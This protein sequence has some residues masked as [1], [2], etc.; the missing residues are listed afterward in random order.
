MRIMSK[1]KFRDDCQPSIQNGMPGVQPFGNK[2]RR[3]HFFKGADIGNL[4][5]SSRQAEKENR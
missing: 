4:D 3:P 1:W 2:N 5:K